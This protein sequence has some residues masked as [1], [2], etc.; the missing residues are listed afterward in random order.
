MTES[1]FYAILDGPALP[2]A[3]TAIG[4]IDMNTAALVLGVL[5]AVLHG[6][7]YFLYN[8]QANRGQSRPNPASWAIWAFLAILNAFSYAKMNGNWYS[9]LQFYTGSVACA[10]TFVNA[11]F[12]GK[13]AKV[14][15]RDKA[16]FMIGL[17]ATIVWWLLKSA[18][19]ANYLVMIVFIISFVPTWQG[20]RENPTLETPQSWI[21]WTIAC[22]CTL[23][24]ALVQG[25]LRSTITPL[26]LL[27]AHGYV[28]V[29]SRRSRQEAYLSLSS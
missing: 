8:L 20:V 24:G 12:M 23:M 22:G 3:T 10:A 15:E 11:L 6:T 17:F 28:A 29:L 7:A 9:A 16:C 1:R 13:F 14:S 5:A 25:H 4:R 19:V 26:V 27:L 18:T 2:Q 21:I